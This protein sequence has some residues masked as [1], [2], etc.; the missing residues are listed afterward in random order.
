MNDPLPGKDPLLLPTAS[1]TPDEFEDFTERL[2]SAH[3][4]CP[5]PLRRIV[6]VERWG[7]K[8]DKQDGIDFEGTWS[9]GTTA[10]WQ[11]KRYD[12]LSVANVKKFV[13]ECTFEADQYYLVYSGEASRDARKEMAEHKNWQLLDRRGLGRLL[14]DLPLHKRRQVLDMTWG[15]QKRKLLLEVPGE[16]AFLSVAAFTSGRQDPEVLLNDCGP[17]IG[18][19]AELESLAMALDRAADWPPIVLVTGPGGRGKTRLVTEALG[20]YEQENLRVPVL[21]LTN[22]RMLDADALRELPHTPA[23]IFVDDAHRDPAAMTP[24]LNYVR[25]TE[26]TQ[27]ILGSRG[28]G[29]DQLR[30]EIV[31]SG[32][33]LDQTQQIPVAE[34]SPR[35]ARQLVASLSEGINVPAAL[36]E[37]LAEQAVDSPHIP[38]LALN[39][40]RR[41]ELSGPLALD[42]GLREQV[43]LRYQD[44]L[45]SDVGDFNGDTVRRALALFAAIGPVDADDGNLIPMLAEF[46][47]MKLVN[48]LRLRESLHER[49][50]LFTRSGRT[51]VVPDI[52][53]DQILERESAVG[54]HD[55]GFAT[56]VWEKLGGPCGPR[57]II[58]LSEL[59]WRLTNQG[60]PSI[61]AP[62]WAALQKELGAADLAG[63][64]V[65]LKRLEPLAY[66]QPQLLLHL[67]EQIR[68]RLDDPENL[69]Q[70]DT[71]PSLLTQ[72][73]ESVLRAGLGLAPVTVSDVAEL[74]PRLYGL[75]ASNALELLEKA[76]DAL[77]S[78]RRQ[79]RREP[80]QHPD[81]ADRIVTD[82][83]TTFGDLPDPSF[84]ARVV[85]CV[86]NW[87]SEPPRVEDTIT[88]MFAL[89]SLVAKE[90]QRYVATSRREISIRP[91]LVSPESAR[92]LRDRIRGILLAQASSHELE[93]AGAA[94][95][96]LGDMLREPFAMLGQAIGEN[97]VSGWENDDLETLATL[98]RVA[99]ATHSPALRR[100]IRHQI[101]WSAEAS[102]SSRVRHAALTLMTE[103]DERTDDLA[104][105]L[106]DNFGLAT[107]RRGRKV[108]PLAELEGLARSEHRARD[109]LDDTEDFGESLERSGARIDLRDKERGER[110]QHVVDD[111]FGRQSIVEA[112]KDIEQCCREI[113][114]IN[115]RGAG[116]RGL[117]ELYQAVASQKPEVIP[118]I[119]IETAL[120]ADGPLDEF[121]HVLLNAWLQNSE[122]ALLQWL[123]ALSAQRVRVRRAVATAFDHYSWTDRGKRFVDLY[124][125]GIKDDDDDVRN[126]FLSGSHRMLAVQP[127][128]TVKLLMGADVSPAAAVDAMEAAAEHNYA[129]WG[130][131]LQGPDAGAVLDLIQY[132]GWRKRSI[133]LIAAGIAFQHPRLVLQELAHAPVDPLKLPAQMEGLA[134]AFQVQSAELVS[135]IVE[136]AQEP[137][138]SHASRV[139]G[140]AM[141]GGMAAAHAADLTLAVGTL[142]APFLV[143]LTAL[144]A[145]VPVWPLRHPDLARRLLE[146]AGSSDAGPVEDIRNRLF[147]AMIPKVWHASGGESEQLEQLHADAIHVASEETHLVLRAE[148]ERVAAYIQ[149]ELEWIQRRYSEDSDF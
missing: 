68:L 11:C 97:D 128:T 2:L 1:L 135:W 101:D 60:G 47:D 85:A 6:R 35:Q 125:L 39:M 77:W 63:L 93:Y 87:L 106:L 52:L 137:N 19:D 28:T 90:G 73:E 33:R 45:A 29:T 107:S 146:Q 55:T 75:C 100:T 61:V 53:A 88:P 111:L 82:Q 126:G 65:A 54:G 41:D 127:A 5:D 148:Y 131:S 149:T 147:R 145:E 4:F 119:V 3:R 49:G 108:P 46:C 140:L 30:A 12:S 141:G 51:R 57:L 81:H 69:E 16:D 59:D 96:L 62:V 92:P 64:R 91:F 78:L 98:A 23:T 132:V 142:D 136:Q 134:G 99:E 74:L 116:G 105:V 43:L 138:N 117:W 122:E 89:K 8:G 32:F 36:S 48:F 66:T 86:E 95:D 71:A 21:C 103:L 104:E 14:E 118:D 13:K 72:N 84:P 18:R 7:R 9:D 26:G 67:I 102:R 139:V 42:V 121:L 114:Q 124:L 112:L 25:S 56:E 79:D 22:G 34:L 38:V 80:H 109:E 17:L 110:L 143:Q 115:R 123:E 24:L 76:L 130:R 133:Q 10:A 37:H 31:R 70:T 113:E 83:L 129:E 44:I 58:T 15:V 144:L 50:L 40:A 20:V 94:V 120:R 27:L